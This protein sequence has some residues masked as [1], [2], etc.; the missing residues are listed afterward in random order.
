MAGKRYMC[1]GYG[2]DKETGEMFYNIAPI[3][4][5]R[6]KDGRP[7]G[8]LQMDQRSSVNDKLSIGEIKT[9]SLIAE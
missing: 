1:V 4:E 8:M 5:G 2:V 9:F 6:T 7:Y 3:L